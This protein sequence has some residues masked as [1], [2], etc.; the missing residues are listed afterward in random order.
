MWLPF[1]SRLLLGAASVVVPSYRRR[2]WRREWDAELWCWMQGLPNTGHSPFERLQLAA[3]CYGAIVDAVC[4][5]RSEGGFESRLRGGLPERPARGLPQPAWSCS[6]WQSQVADS[7]IPARRYSRARLLTPRAQRSS[8]KAVRLWAA[9]TAFPRRRSSIGIATRNRSKARR[10]TCPIP[11]W[12][13]AT[14]Q[15]FAKLQRR[16][17]G[18]GSS[19][20]WGPRDGGS[21]VY[22]E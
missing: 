1:E 4:I 13:G 20:F 11:V 12:P 6:R 7:G 17:L 10:Y 16:R 18:R 14:G 9:G 21:S 19:I 22:G 8:R 3:H 5:R 2:E 15:A